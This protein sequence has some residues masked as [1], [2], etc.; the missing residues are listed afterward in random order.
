MSFDPTT[1]GPDAN[2]YVDLAFADDYFV[3][4]IDS[5]WWTAMNQGQKEAYLVTATQALEIWVD[6]RG[7][8]ATDTQ[9]LHFPATGEDCKGNDFPDGEI[10]LAI[11]QA[12]CEQASFYNGLN[13]TELPTALLQGLSS[14][15]VGSLK[16]AFDKMNVPGRL[17]ETA[18]GL[19]ACY[20]FLK[21]GANGGYGSGSMIITRL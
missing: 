15:Q 12:V 16:A 2:S 13:A 19:V 9:A 8:P 11:K 4:R 14:A 3:T 17:G 1:G 18:K 21:P 5:A 10:P 20:G 7:E 6:W